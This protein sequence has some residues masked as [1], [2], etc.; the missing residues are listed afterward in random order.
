M[1]LVR[2][3]IIAVLAAA[4]VVAVAILLGA[5]PLGWSLLFGLIGGALALVAALLTGNT[6]PNWSPAPDPAQAATNL[7][8]STLTARLSE[9]AKDEYRYHTRIQPR[10][11]KLV[12]GTLRQRPELRDLTDLA[13]P[14]V[15]ALLGD[16]LHTML[17]ARRGALPTPQR[18]TRL[19]ARLE[20]P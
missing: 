5:I 9:A 4:A 1:T 14:R 10:L 16:D 2:S 6:E 19:L 11:R 12:L 17:T 3:I 8:A 18:V 13:D 15:R 20:E 7:Q